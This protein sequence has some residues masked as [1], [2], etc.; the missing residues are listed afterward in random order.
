SLAS[1]A[2]TGRR[3]ASR[4]PRVPEP[5]FRRL[6]LA[7][8]VAVVALVGTGAWVRLSE[9]G[10]GCP[11]WPECYGG[12]LA[13][14]GSYHS[15]VEFVNRCVIT[16]VAVLIGAAV[17]AAIW[18]VRRRRDLVWLSFGLFAGY[19]SEAVL[20]GLTVLA[21]LTPALVAAHLVVAML[22][23]ADAVVLHWRAGRP[24][25]PAGPAAGRDARR[26]ARLLL[27]TLAAV[28]IL[29]TVVAG[30]GPYA[31]SRD[32]PRFAFHFQSAAELHAVVVMFLVGATVATYF[33]LRA[34]AAAPVAQRAYHVLLAVT[35]AQGA[36]GYAQYFS[37]LPVLLVEAHI[38][39][40]AVLVVAAVRFNLA[41]GTDRAAAPRPA[42]DAPLATDRSR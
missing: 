20:G 30:A 9:S 38:L 35:V 24:P 39:G 14:N 12:R 31:G 10:L 42:V 16:A 1:T 17:L 34:D 29:G 19:V 37:G 32:V 33:A 21:K 25:G 28:V 8:V 18:S 5:L 6:A 15:L 3:L 36:I 27:V 41:V 26:L 22:L 40:A 7:N 4:L 11:T 2:P 23:L 13:A